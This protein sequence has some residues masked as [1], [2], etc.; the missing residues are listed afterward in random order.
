MRCCWA[1]QVLQVIPCWTELAF[2]WLPDN[3]VTSRQLKLPV[4]QWPCTCTSKGAQQMHRSGEDGAVGHKQV[5]R[6]AGSR[7]GSWHAACQLA[8]MVLCSAFRT[9]PIVWEKGRWHCQPGQCHCGVKGQLPSGSQRQGVTALCQA[10]HSSQ[11]A[12]LPQPSTSSVGGSA[13][14]CK[15]WW[16]WCAAHLQEAGVLC[17]LLNGVATVPQDALVT[18]NEGDARLDSCGVHVPA[19]Q[20]SRCLSCR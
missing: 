2:V 11:R 8:Q 5:A 3:Q 1:V 20:T 7:P 19:A 10:L 4:A 13:C 17:Q 14:D 18:I 9:G 6:S 15:Q 16:F 12:H